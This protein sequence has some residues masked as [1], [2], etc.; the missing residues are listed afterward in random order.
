MAVTQQTS[1][2][3]I[4]AAFQ[5]NDAEQAILEAVKQQGAQPAAKSTKPR[6]AKTNL[7]AK[8]RTD[9]KA[10]TKAADIGDLVAQI[11]D[12]IGHYSADADIAKGS[13]LQHVESLLR[14]AMD[15]GLTDEMLKA[16]TKIE[17][18]EC[19][20]LLVDAIN[21]PRLANGLEELKSS[22]RDN[23]M[24]K[25]RAFL[26]SRGA[27]ALDLF[28]NIAKTKAKAAS[29]TSEPEPE[30]DEA[31]ADEAEQAT[32]RTKSPASKSGAPAHLIG[33]PAVH[34]FLTEWVAAN[35]AGTISAEWRD[36]IID[37]ND[38]LEDLL[39]AK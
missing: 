26:R 13:L 11:G 27:E 35:P 36:K 18:R 9:K 29:K 38:E 7:F 5:P 12:E 1:S 31:E 24:S 2:G 23:Y 19:Y 34:A 25:M 14:K 3:V 16:P 10:D 22:V 37:L 32:S 6:A 21:A 15:A 17:P 20:V 28:G 4:V 33:L 8:V 39:K 30:A